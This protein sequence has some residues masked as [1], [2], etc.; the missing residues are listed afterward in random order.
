MR[1]DFTR[2]FRRKGVA[3]GVLLVEDTPCS[4]VLY[5]FINV[6]YHSEYTSH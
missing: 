1:A 4:R 5:D 3:S 6:G 2:I